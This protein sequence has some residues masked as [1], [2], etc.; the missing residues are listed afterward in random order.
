MNQFRKKQLEFFLVFLLWCFLSPV[1]FAGEGLSDDKSLSSEKR[2][3]PSHK[4]HKDAV[5]IYFLITVEKN[6]EKLIAV[7]HQDA[8]SVRDAFSEIISTARIGKE[9]SSPSHIVR[10][11]FELIITDIYSKILVKENDKSFSQWE[12]SIK[13]IASDPIDTLLKEF[14]D[15]QTLHSSLFMNL[16]VHDGL[17]RACCR[18]TPEVYSIFSDLLDYFSRQPSDFQKI[19]SFLAQ[20][21]EKE[22][23]DEERRESTPASK[24]QASGQSSNIDLGRMYY[25]YGLE[26]EDKFYERICY[27]DACI[28]GYDKALL[29]VAQIS[30]P[31]KAFA[32]YLFSAVQREIAEGYYEIGKMVRDGFEI[33]K[34]ILRAQQKAQDPEFWFEQAIANKSTNPVS[35]DFSTSAAFDLA[36]IYEKQDRYDEAIVVYGILENKGYIRGF[37]EHGR[38]LENQGNYE[39]ALEIYKKPE[40]KWFGAVAQSKLATTSQERNTFL[41]QADKI[42]DAHFDELIGK[43]QLQ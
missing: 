2:E 16:Q 19:K 23:E 8:H 21:K 10:S 9:L 4:K 31:Q 14:K 40:L 28:L 25:E 26:T 3:R 24:K 32:Y 37:L 29:D 1:S 17:A 20:Y 5:Q 38:I 6:T 36:E 11:V 30:E 41:D 7:C 12:P 13:E 39:G 27:L 33:P 43:A 35:K 22:S 34:E 18:K 42:F 15:G